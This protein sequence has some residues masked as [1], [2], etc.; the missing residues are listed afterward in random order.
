MRNLIQPAFIAFSLMLGL[1]I[2]AEGQ[3]WTRFRGPNGSGISQATHIPTQWTADDYLWRTRLPGKGHSSPVVWGHRLFLLSADP[4]DATR[5]VLC[6][7]TET[8]DI[9]WQ[10]E[11]A[12]QSHHLHLRNSFASSTPA[13]DRQHVYVTWATPE[14]LRLTVLDHQGDVVWKVN[15][16][17]WASQ[18]GYAISPILYDDLVILSHSQQP[19][20]QS[21]NVLGSQENAATRESNEPDQ[22]DENYMVAFDRITG[23]LR[24]KT[25]RRP[26]RV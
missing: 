21:S 12:S 23:Q 18:H 20:P 5:Y 22:L 6:L 3:D 9:L 2:A 10:K 26:S 25:V 7:D 14:A 16:G 4:A 1:A 24:W 15:L 11:F 13:V 19:E 17:R 8:G